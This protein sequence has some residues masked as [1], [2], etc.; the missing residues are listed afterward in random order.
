L[1]RRAVF[2]VPIQGCGHYLDPPLPVVIGGR[3]LPPYQ[4][5]IHTLKLLVSGQGC[6]LNFRW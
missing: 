1:W 5:V 4:R 2:A 6:V 3:H